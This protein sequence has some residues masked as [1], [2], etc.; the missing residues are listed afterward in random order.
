MYKAQARD[1]TENHNRIVKLFCSQLGSMTSFT[2]LFKLFYFYSIFFFIYFFYFIFFFFLFFFIFF[3]L[4]GGGGGGW[5][6]VDGDGLFVPPDK[7]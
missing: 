5:R 6:W 7:A 4:F 2:A 3:F 1:Y